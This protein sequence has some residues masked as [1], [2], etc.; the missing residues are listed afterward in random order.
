MFFFRHSLTFVIYAAL[1]LFILDIHFQLMTATGVLLYYC[2]HMLTHAH[3]NIEVFFLQIISFFTFMKCILVHF[4]FYLFYFILFYFISY[5]SETSSWAFCFI[6]V[7]NFFFTHV[8]EN[9]GLKTNLL[10]YFILFYFIFY[11]RETS[12]WVFCFGL[13]LL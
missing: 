8:L 9:I 5:S 6:T 4:S 1:V 10:F 7:V 2:C 11:S 13:L 12:S 3:E